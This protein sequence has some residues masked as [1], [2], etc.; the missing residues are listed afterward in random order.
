ARAVEY[1]ALSYVW[2]GDTEA[3]G[4]TET[5]VPAKVPVVI[6]DAMQACA[7]LGLPYLWADL[8]CVHQNDPVQKAADIDSMG[9]IYRHARITLVAGRYRGD[10]EGDVR[11]THGIWRLFPASMTDDLGA[12]Q[13]IETV[14]GRQY[15]TALP[16]TIR[17]I[18]SS[19]WHR[20][21]WTYQEGALARRIAFFGDYDILYMCGAGHWRQ[22]MHSGAHGHDGT[23]PGIDLRSKGYYTLSARHW[24]GSDEWRFEDY[25]DMVHGYTP[26]DLT[27]ESDRLNAI[28]GCLN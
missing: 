4:V 10:K 16:Q 22:A 24:L 8:Y 28:S 7:Q 6:A 25:L 1:A 2:G 13:R 5:F 21:G 26:R 20:R 14:G 17:Q 9:H 15:I 27:Y 11:K 18:H 3:A 23:M 12:R 19:A